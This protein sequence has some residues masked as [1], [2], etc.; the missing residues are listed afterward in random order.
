MESSRIVFE[1]RICWGFA[2]PFSNQSWQLENPERRVEDV[3]IICVNH[4]ALSDAMFDEG[5][6]WKTI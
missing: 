2:L 5:T 3:E 6:L 4:G 1:L